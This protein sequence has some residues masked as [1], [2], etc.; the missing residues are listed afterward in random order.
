MNDTLKITSGQDW[1]F[2]MIDQMYEQV[3]KIAVDEFGLDC[4]TNQIDIISAEQMLDAYCSAG[5]PIYYPHWSFGEQFVKQYEA[6]KRGHMSLAYEIVINSNPCVSYLMEENTMLMQTLVTAHAAFGHNFFFKNNYAF[7]NWTKADEIVDYLSYAKKYINECYERYGVDEVEAVLDAAHALKFYSV[8]K[9]KRPPELSEEELQQKRFEREQQRQHDLNL[10][11]TTIPNRDELGERK[12]GD[13]FYDFFPK[14]PQENILR[15]VEENAPRL[16]NWKREVIRIV[17]NISQYFKPQ[18]QTKTMNEACACWFHYK[19]IHRLYEK[20]YVDQSAMQE[21]YQSHTNVTFQP[22]YNDQRFSGLN[23]YVIGFSIA[24]D[25]ERVCVN[26]TDEDKEWFAN[27]WWVGN[28]DP[29]KT[30]KW[31]FSN[32]NDE[33]YIR[34]FLS[35]K[36]MRDLKLFVVHDDEQDPKLEVAAIHDEKGYKKL[37]RRMADS[38]QLDN[39]FPDI[40]V[41][42]VDRW[43]DRSL[44]LTH[45]LK[46]DRQLHH[47]QTMDTLVYLKYL[48]GYAVE[49][50]SVCPDTNKLKARFV[51]HADK[52]S[53]NKSSAE[54]DDYIDIVVSDV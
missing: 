19:I 47:Q 33:S 40:Q 34:Q 17:R 18:M 13:N 43:G 9:Y 7:K 10:L 20:G 31:V 2:D 23:P 27:Q 11:W 8:D 44:T 36:L 50:H 16:E 49:L 22:N 54:V 51:S 24:R 46:D 32:F 38:Y 53:N 52:A 3:R 12:K 48:W 14:E 39:N 25:I 29:I 26:P 4:Y 35:P 6:Y 45:Y 37:R 30:M 1:S 21:F 15:F 42:N 28:Q 41:T 5:L